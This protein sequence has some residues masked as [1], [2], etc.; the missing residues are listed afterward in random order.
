MLSVDQP[1]WPRQVEPL[2]DGIG[3]FSLEL[4]PKDRTKYLIVLSNVGAKM[5]GG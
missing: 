4:Y 2:D 3:S 5:Q 1:K